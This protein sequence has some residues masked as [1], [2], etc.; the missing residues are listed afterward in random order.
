MRQNS[1][2][3]SPNTTLYNKVQVVNINA[4]GIMS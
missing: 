4:L 2:H 1:T 3:I